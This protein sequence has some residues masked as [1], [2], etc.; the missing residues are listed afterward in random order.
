MEIYRLSR[1]KLI[2]DYYVTYKNDAEDREVLLEIFLKYW[3]FNELQGKITCFYVL[4][5][6]NTLIVGLN[7]ARVTDVCPRFSVWGCPV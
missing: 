2:L 5:T 7:P 6:S 3:K 1:E 4:E